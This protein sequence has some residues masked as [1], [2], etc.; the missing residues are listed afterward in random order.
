MILYRAKIA[1][2][3]DESHQKNTSS[4]K[5]TGRENT[6]SEVEFKFEDKTGKD[7]FAMQYPPRRENINF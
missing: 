7:A 3:G 4:D 2:Y 1:S 6:V 5:M